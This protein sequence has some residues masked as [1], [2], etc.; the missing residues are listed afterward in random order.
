MHATER[1]GNGGMAVDGLYS[2]KRPC[3]MV[4]EVLVALLFATVQSKSQ[5]CQQSV[6]SVCNPWLELNCRKQAENAEQTD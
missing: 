1:D 4:G 3:N 5:R 6:Q 2:K